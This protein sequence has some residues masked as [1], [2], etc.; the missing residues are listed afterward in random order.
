MWIMLRRKKRHGNLAVWVYFIATT[1]AATHR[2]SPG[3]TV[4]PAANAVMKVAASTE[5]PLLTDDSKVIT[6]SLTALKA[7][8]NLSG[9]LRTTKFHCRFREKGLSKPPV[10]DAVRALFSI[11]CT[12]KKI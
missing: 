12:S 11:A 9:L 3:T 2:I 6:T 4:V 8:I 5:F 10:I 7:E 1:V